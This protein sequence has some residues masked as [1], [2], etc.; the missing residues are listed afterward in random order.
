MT[1]QQRQKIERWLQQH[2]GTPKTGEYWCNMCG[3]LYDKTWL[4]SLILDT[5]PA[6]ICPEC[7]KALL[8]TS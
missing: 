5:L 3:E 4:Y 2:A 7:L 6:N 8:K 1:T